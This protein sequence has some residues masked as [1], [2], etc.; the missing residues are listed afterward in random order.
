MED[1]FNRLYFPKERTNRLPRDSSHKFN[2]TKVN[3]KIAPE[4]S[5]FL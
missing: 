1:D 3:F 5:K 4:H 2:Y